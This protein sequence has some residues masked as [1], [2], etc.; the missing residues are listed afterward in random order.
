MVKPD[1]PIA[2]IQRVRTSNGS[3]AM[4]VTNCR[5]SRRATGKPGNDSVEISP[6]ARRL[7]DLESFLADDESTEGD[8]GDP[9]KDTS[10]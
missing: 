6:R 1:D 7:A 4:P 5:V 10:R 9:E 8:G 3:Q 2:G